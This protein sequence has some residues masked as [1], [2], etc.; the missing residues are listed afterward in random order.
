M[1]IYKKKGIL[2]RKNYFYRL[3]VAEFLKDFRLKSGQ[4]N[5]N[6]KCIAFHVR[7]GDRVIQGKLLFCCD[8]IKQ[9]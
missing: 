4:N 2:F 1:C 3:K 6:E 8:V 5:L 9:L 7:R